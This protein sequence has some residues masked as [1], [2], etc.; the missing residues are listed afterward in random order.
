MER[1]VEVLKALAHPLRLKISLGLAEKGECHVTA[2]VDRLGVPQATVSNQLAVLRKAGV[3]RQER[4]GTQVCYYLES[5]TIKK[6][7]DCIRSC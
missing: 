1:H 3:I 4:K 6:L 7:L 5:E 2:M